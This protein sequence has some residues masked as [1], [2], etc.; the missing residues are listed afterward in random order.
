VN[1][2]FITARER[3]VCKIGIARDVDA[4][5]ASLQTASPVKLTVEA[6]IPGSRDLERQ[7]H[8]RFAEHRLSGEWF[9]ITDELDALIAESAA[10]VV[11]PLPVTKPLTK[12]LSD[13]E[14]AD[15]SVARDRVLFAEAMRDFERAGL[16]VPTEMP[17]ERRRFYEPV[18]IS[19]G[20]FANHYGIR[21]HDGH[22]HRVLCADLNL[23]WDQAD[24]L[25]DILEEV[26]EY[27]IEERAA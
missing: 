23:G 22:R 3:N 11:V 27:A 20:Q 7:L 24:R 8:E 15:R 5:R 18:P 6:V 1:V 9:T 21:G 10:N 16:T 2:Y 26:R 14:L 17:R 12:R 19:G 25:C 4:R 13:E